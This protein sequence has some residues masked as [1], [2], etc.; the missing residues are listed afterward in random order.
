[1]TTDIN[2][3]INPKTDHGRLVLDLVEAIQDNGGVECE[4]LPDIF[5]PEDFRAKAKGH[6][7]QMADMAE[8]TA[9][10]IC[11]RCPVIAQ[12]LKVGLYE[13][14]GIFGGTTAKQRQQIRREQQ[15]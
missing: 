5:F 6:D 1:M 7:Y 15:I 13:E 8:K 14:Y 12:C 3:I 10:E 4:Q 2:K 9:R 11:M